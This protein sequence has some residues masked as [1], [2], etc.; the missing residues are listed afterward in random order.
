MLK[1][2]G[3]W[4]LRRVTSVKPNGNY[5]PEKWESVKKVLTIIS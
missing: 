1:S 3:N 4:N 5:K 2:K